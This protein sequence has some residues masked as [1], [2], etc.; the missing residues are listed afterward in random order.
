MAGPEAGAHTVEFMDTLGTP[1]ERARLW[2]SP[3]RASL[4]KTLGAASV[5]LPTPCSCGFLQEMHF[6]LACSGLERM[7]P[8]N[9]TTPYRKPMA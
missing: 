4:R 1:E 2:A 6:G 9:P 7:P 5:V 3:G 8:I